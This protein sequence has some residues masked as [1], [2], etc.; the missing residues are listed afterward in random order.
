MMDNK[1]QVEASAKPMEQVAESVL[2]FHSDTSGSTTL[3]YVL[4]LAAIGFP[5]YVIITHTLSM[6]LDFY[7]MMTAVNALPFP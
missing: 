4:L 2:R 5:S 3:E 7:Q 1:D 6:L